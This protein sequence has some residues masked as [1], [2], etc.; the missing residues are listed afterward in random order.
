MKL[1]KL[2]FNNF[3]GPGTIAIGLLLGGAALFTW[4]L[5]AIEQAS[6]D[7]MP[8]RAVTAAMHA[9]CAD[10]PRGSQEMED[11]RYECFNRL[12]GYSRYRITW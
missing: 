10:L 5:W 7:D 1:I 2:L 9:K 11:R 3:T 4:F 12:Y 8:I 6:A